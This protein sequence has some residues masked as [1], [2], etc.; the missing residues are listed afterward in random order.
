MFDQVMFDCHMNYGPKSLVEYTIC[1]ST[2]SFTV[3]RKRK[4]YSSLD[5]LE[6]MK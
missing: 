6:M 3:R 4:K 1:R 2:F 5:R